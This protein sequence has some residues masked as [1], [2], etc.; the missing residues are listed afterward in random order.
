M[1]LDIVIL[2]WNNKSMGSYEA[3]YKTV[4]SYLQQEL[5]E[6]HAELNNLSEDQEE[7]R[8][9]QQGKIYELDRVLE[10]LKVNEPVQK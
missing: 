4:L 5:E 8:I 3:A 7:A 1:P 10:Y 9:F 2:L 6:E